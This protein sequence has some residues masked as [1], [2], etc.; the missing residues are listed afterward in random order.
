M[1]G[2]VNPLQSLA[3][4]VR[5]QREAEGRSES[6]ERRMFEALGLDWS[7]VQQ[8]RR[9]AARQSLER[10]SASRGMPYQPS[11]PGMNPTLMALRSREALT[12][13]E[14]AAAG[15][16]GVGW[17][18]S[19]QPVGQQ[20]EIDFTPRPQPNQARNVVVPLTRAHTQSA[21]TGGPAR[22]AG[23]RLARL[24]G[25]SLAG[26]GGALGALAGLSEPENAW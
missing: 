23:A 11:L 9:E 1:A 8:A 4:T 14:M 12:P 16:V 3:N 6:S 18:P 25:F 19:T 21:A 24:L 10:A 20:L 2:G 26:G 22:F 7:A 17:Q 15:V 5:I 13:Q